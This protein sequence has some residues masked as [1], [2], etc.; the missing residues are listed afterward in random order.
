MSKRI[1]FFGNERLATGVH[2]SVP[3]LRALLN[4]DYEIPAIVIAQNQTG[5]SRR[6][7]LLEVSETAQKRNIPLLSPVD[8]AEARDQLAGFGAEAAVLIAYGKIVPAAILDLFP[9]G[10]I[11]VHP[12]LLP[13]HRGPAPIENTI[14]NGDEE[15]GVSLMRL[16]AEMDTGPVYAQRTLSLNGNET[17]QE[18]A[19]RLLALGADLVMEYLPKVLDGSAEPIPQ[20]EAA[21]TYDHLITKADGLVDWTKSALRL[22]REV[23]AYAGWPRSR[24]AFFGKEAVVTKAHVAGTGGAGQPGGLRIEGR[25]LG[26]YTGQGVLVIDSL[27]PAGKKEMTAAA[28]LAGYKR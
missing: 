6:E 25:E 1:L 5:K 8:L 20:D 19:D 2:S 21:A 22:E 11:N 7:R 28:F 16:A 10:V 26:V 15:T 9:R 18:L 14:L 17:K 3:T 24:T 12:S 27:I 13:R 23:R 4:A